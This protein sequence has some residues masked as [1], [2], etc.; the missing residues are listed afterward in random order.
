[1]SFKLTNYYLFILVLIIILL[2]IGLLIFTNN[3]I[4]GFRVIKLE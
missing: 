1:M 2:F 3:N 4:S